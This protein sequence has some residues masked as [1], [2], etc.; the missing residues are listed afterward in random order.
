MNTRDPLNVLLWVV[1]IFVVVVFL[2]WLV[3]E[4]DAETADAMAEAFFVRSGLG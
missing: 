1:V 3:R 2:I 4:L